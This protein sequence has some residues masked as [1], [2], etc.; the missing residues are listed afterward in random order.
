M[1]RSYPYSRR[2][3]TRARLRKRM[4]AMA[5]AVV[6]RMVIHRRLVT[7]LSMVSVALTALLGA[8]WSAVHA[9]G[10]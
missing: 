10:F 5:A 8:V 1:D 2:L 7:I 9:N 6:R 3:L 4:A